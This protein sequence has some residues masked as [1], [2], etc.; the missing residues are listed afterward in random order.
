MGR[1]GAKKAKTAK[2]NPMMAAMMAAMQQQQDSSSDDEADLARVRAARAA[3]WA[4]AVPSSSNPTAAA[5]G[6]LQVAAAAAEDGASSAKAAAAAPVVETGHAVA[7][8]MANLDQQTASLYS[9]QDNSRRIHRNAVLLRSIP[10]AWFESRQQCVLSILF[11]K[12]PCRAF[13]MRKSV[14]LNL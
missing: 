10:K 12:P 7:K 6:H 4:D 2:M 5:S 13:D 1:H 8:A 9:S 3:S 11:Q 14:I